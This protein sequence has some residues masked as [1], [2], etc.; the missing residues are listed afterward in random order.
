M[1]IMITAMTPKPLSK[2]AQ[3]EIGFNWIY[4]MIAGVVIL[5]FFTGII[6]RQKASSEQQLS[7][8]VVRIMGSIFTAAGV[9]EK[10]KNSIDISG[11]AD[12]TLTFYCEDGVGDYGLKDGY[13]VQNA[14]EPVFAPVE[15]QGT[16]LNL[17]S[18]PYKFPFKVTDFLFITSENTKYFF[19]GQDV[20]IDEFLDQT[21][22]DEK[23]R[24]KINTQRISTLEQLK[25]EN[26]FQIRVVDFSSTIRE[27]LSVPVSVQQLGDDKVTAI[28]FTVAGNVDYYQKQDIVWKKLNPVPVPIISLGG[29]RDA[30]KYAAIFAG[31]DQVYLCNM[32][33]AFRRLKLLNEIYGGKDIGN[34][35]IGGKLQEM[36]TYYEVDHP[37]FLQSRPDCVNTLHLYPENVANSLASLQ[38]K[39]AA[40]LY[41]PSRCIDLISSAAELKELNENLRTD[42]L[43]LY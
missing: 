29:E 32:Q 41:L 27:G 1:N 5:L 7:V 12:Y 11:L 14:I 9:S 40:C 25:P 30:A 33:K 28:V 16:R 34:G 43:T 37:E 38:N 22:A 17:W 21:A 8:D 15:I 4:I 20:F 31:N 36:I 10:T 23:I 13:Q 18:L 3:L 19:L 6:V 39:A 42:C 2:K 35:D 26:N 24:F